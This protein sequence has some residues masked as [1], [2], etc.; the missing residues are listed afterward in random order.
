VAS[1]FAPASN[2]LVLLCA[3]GAAD[4][5]GRP[6][7]I[8]SSKNLVGRLKRTAFCALPM[9]MLAPAAKVLSRRSSATRLPPSST[10]AM[11]LPGAFC[12]SLRQP[13]R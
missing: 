3:G 4:A 13:P 1:A 10:T 11:A 8:M 7:L 9:E 6:L 12:F 2:L 5:N